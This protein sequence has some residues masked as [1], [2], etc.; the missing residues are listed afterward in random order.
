MIGIGRTI[1]MA[2]FLAKRTGEDMRSMGIPTVIIGA[3]GIRVLVRHRTIDPVNT[4]EDTAAQR[5]VS[6]HV[7]VVAV[8]T[9][10]VITRNIASVAD[11]SLANL[12][13]SIT[14]QTFHI[15]SSD[16]SRYTVLSHLGYGRDRQIH[17]ITINSI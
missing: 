13:L 5:T 2:W 1:A 17:L 14:R 8:V 16:F 7:H 11:F 9:E 10:I 6:M 4:V 12:G 3:A 15:Y